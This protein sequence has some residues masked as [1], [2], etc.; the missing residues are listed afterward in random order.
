M[1]LINSISV[2][3][4]FI[5]A[6]ASALPRELK[7][8]NKMFSGNP[9]QITDLNITSIPN[10]TVSMAFT[11]YDPDPL[12]N[13]TTDCA[14]SW[15]YGSNDYPQAIYR[16]CGNTSVAWHMQDFDDVEDIEDAIDFTVEIKDTFKDPT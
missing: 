8:Q 16:S 15:P 13:T 5:A 1:Q 6:T 2:G 9:F 11:V 12:A 14:S 3:I 7:I 10:G 4:A